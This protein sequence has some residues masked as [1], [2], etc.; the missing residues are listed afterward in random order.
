[1]F[2][3]A[4]LFLAAILFSAISFSQSETKRTARPFDYTSTSIYASDELSGALGDEGIQ[5]R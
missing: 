5:K 1:M 4:F 2:Y 3:R